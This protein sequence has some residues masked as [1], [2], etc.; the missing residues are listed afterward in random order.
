MFKIALSVPKYLQNNIIFKENFHRDDIYDRFIKLKQE[1]KKY[2]YDLSTNDINSIEESEIVIYASNMPKILPMDDKINSSYVILTES[3]FIRPDN[4]DID[5]HK[6]FKKVFT[7]HDNLVD[8]AKYIKLN[9]ANKFPDTINK[10]KLCVLISANKNPPYSKEKDLYSKR[11]EAIKWFEN[12]KPNDFDLFGVGWDS[13][14]F[15]G[16]RLIGYLNLIPNLGKVYTKYKGISY[17]SYKGKID[18][19]K[20]VMEK[21]KFSIC[22]EN[23]KDIPGYITENI[24]DS[25]VAGCVPIYWGANNILDYVP[26]D[27]FIDKRDFKTYKELYSFITSISDEEYLIYLNNIEEYL[28]SEAAL[29]FK[30]EGFVNTIVSTILKDRNGN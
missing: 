30:S 16:N 5:K 18:N 14:H 26:K 3:S 12:N 1:F 27:C 2:N 15:T 21:Y 10:D 13:Y 20:E 6:Y 4:Y 23:A 7:W 8:D 28:K 29:Q 9:Y 22:F 25:F 24:F 17:P 19:K 11:R